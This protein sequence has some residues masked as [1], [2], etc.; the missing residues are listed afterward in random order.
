MTESR[1]KHGRVRARIG[2][3]FGS[4]AAAA[5]A[6][7]C[8]TPVPAF[9]PHDPSRGPGALVGAAKPAGVP[10]FGGDA[11]VDPNP[12]AGERP[13]DG[14]LPSC[15]PACEAHCAGLELENPVD[16]AVCPALWGVS[17]D[18]RPIVEA[19]ACRRLFVDLVGRFPSRAEV[20]GQCAGRPFGEV[21]RAL[22]GTPAFVELNQ[23]RWA[24]R[25]L[26][27]AQAVSIERI[28]DMDRLVGKLYRGEIAYDEFAAVASAHPVLTRRHATPGDR[29]EA[30][31]GLFLGRPPY[32]NERSDLARLYALW[33][34][35]YYDHPALGMRLPD[36]VVAY[37]CTRPDGTIDPAVKGEC[38]SVLWGYN[39][40]VLRPDI[41]A[42]RAEQKDELQMWSGL[43]RPQEWQKLQAPG[44]LLARQRLGFWEHAVGEVLNQYLGYDLGTSVPAVRDRLVAFVLKHGGDIRAAHHAILTSHVYL[45]SATGATPTA[46][47][48]TYGPLKQVDAEPWLD[49]IKQATGFKL[50]RCDHRFPQPELFLRSGSVAAYALVER[51]RWQIS[52][53]R[54]VVDDYAGVAKTLGGCPDNEVGGRFKTVSVLTT[55]TQESLVRKLCNPTLA[56]GEGAAPIAKLLPAGLDPRRALDPD[57]GEEIY[58]HQVG[59]FFGRAL[60]DEERTEARAAA[61]GCARQTCTAEAFARPVCSA[62]L[63]SSEMIFY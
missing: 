32:E 30:L 44:R 45:Q 11:P 42:R 18:T 5:L 51:S 4:L 29:A 25:F 35:G 36:A 20:D 40:L 26:Y 7:S 2:S 50:S 57:L 34:N 14:V 53:S 62:L 23:R 54:D 49:S 9:D 60:S 41:R 19:E 56:K 47:R 33:E 43:L 6:A 3:V 46:H 48:W 8:G 22:M 16:Q 21:V 38:T 55:A 27:N 63:S 59:L 1:A 12:A 24:D 28:F 52:S 15:G 58:D 31:F 13:A 61:E 39:E 10:A 37:R 17:L